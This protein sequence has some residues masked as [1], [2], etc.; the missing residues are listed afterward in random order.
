MKDQRGAKTLADG[1]AMPEL[2]PRHDD[3]HKGTFG[4]VLVVGG[5]QGMIGAPA[6][7]GAAA[8]RMG[9]GLV[10]VA[11]PA[12]V[13]P[14]VLSAVPELV[15]IALSGGRSGQFEKMV[16]TCQSVVVGPGLGDSSDAVRAL[17]TALKATGPVVIDAGA[18]TLLAEGKAMLRRKP[19]SSV[20]TP[21]PGELARL[22]GSTSAHVQADRLAAGAAKTH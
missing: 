20:L 22:L 18:L 17:A 8:L 19:M 12:E 7:A 4:K 13:L 15:G 16:Q 6:F 2:P 1:G 11:S 3:G 21:H 10:Y 5:S 9:C 14:F